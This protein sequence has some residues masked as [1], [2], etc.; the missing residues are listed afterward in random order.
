MH[1]EAWTVSTPE[2]DEEGA[3][4]IVDFADSLGYDARTVDP[5][6]YY[7]RYMD[8]GDGRDSSLLDARRP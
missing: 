2:I 1:K 4:K 8:R 7:I 6:Y 3:Q 5:A